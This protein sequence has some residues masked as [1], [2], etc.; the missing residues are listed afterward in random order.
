EV[1]KSDYQITGS[2][3]VGAWFKM[4]ATPTNP[5]LIGKGGAYTI[6]FGST[7][8]RV[9]NNSGWMV[10]AIYGQLN[11]NIW[12]LAVVTW[13]TNSR[14]IYID[15]SV[16]ASDTGGTVSDSSDPLTLGKISGN[17]GS[18]AGSFWAGSI[19]EP[20]VTDVALT[21]AQIFDMYNSG[22]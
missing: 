7:D 15:G 18:T 17:G 13:A 2:M 12:H 10:P 5:D 19:D 6:V 11:N 3:S 20:F 22:R 4:P 8:I 9:W 1:R 16:W 21:A 14:I